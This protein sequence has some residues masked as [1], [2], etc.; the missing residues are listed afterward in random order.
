MTYTFFISYNSVVTQV[1][2][3]NWPS[4]ALVDK[5]EDGNIFYRR[6]FEGS[7]T[8]GGKKLCPDFD[9]LYDIEKVSP[10]ARIDLLILLDTDVYWEGY[11]STSNGTWNL[12]EKTFTVT[13]SVTDD[14]SD[15]TDEGD[16]EYNIL[17]IATTVTVRCNGYIYTRNRWL[18]DVIEFISDKTFPGCTVISDFFTLAADYVT[19]NPSKLLYL[20]IAAKSDIKRPTS[21][22]QAT[23]AMMSFNKLMN[24]LKMFNAYWVYDP[25]SNVVTIEH[26]S[27]FNNI[28]GPDLTTQ[29]IAKDMLEYSYAKDKM[30]KYERFSFMEAST[31]GLTYNHM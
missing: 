20:T 19:L 3:L 12:K 26:V 23:Q 25:A 31:D 28:S 11:F 6:K 7:L 14:Y 17:D 8:F 21:S 10:Y 2:P 5:K 30:P 18:W 27:R 24:I 22:D 13:P 1:Y 29:E 15:W 9:L 16:L 4:C